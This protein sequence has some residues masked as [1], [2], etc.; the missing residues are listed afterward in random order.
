MAIEKLGETQKRAAEEGEGDV[1]E[2]RRNS[3][4]KN[5]KFLS[6]KLFR[7]AESVLKRNNYKK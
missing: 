7:E 6:E 3:G 2:K 1:G 5:I 4:N